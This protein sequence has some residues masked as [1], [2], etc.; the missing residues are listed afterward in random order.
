MNGKFE[1]IQWGRAILLT[2]LSLV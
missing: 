2:L 1:F